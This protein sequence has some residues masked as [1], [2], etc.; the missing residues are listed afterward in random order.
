VVSAD[1]ETAR[2]RL[3][4]A[5]DVALPAAQMIYGS[6]RPWVGTV[7]IGLSL[8][9]EHGPAAIEAFLAERANIFL[10]L[11][12]HDIP[13]TVELA[14]R[15]AG[16]LGVSYLTVHA[17]GGAAMLKAA[18]AGSAEGAERAGFAA[19][20]ILAVTVLTSLKDEDL[21][22]AGHTREMQDVA[23]RLAELAS[24]SGVHGVV[25]SPHEASAIRARFPSLF[26]CTPGVRPSGE[27]TQDQ[28]R[29]H[30]PKAAI[31]AGSNLLVVGRPIYEAAD[32]AQAAERICDEIR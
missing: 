13:N 31:A 29:A 11:K 16:A 21:K 10:D 27:E 19:P 5:A 4:F 22:S 26:I 7:K 32:A 8:F 2:A 14:A 24:A 17:Q 15:R 20:K 25:C 1:V 3:A 6:I 18:V 12:L 30:T 23:T 9:V 28:A